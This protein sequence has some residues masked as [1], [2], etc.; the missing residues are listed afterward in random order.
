MST[1][2][3]MIGCRLPHGL[4]LEVGYTVTQKAPDGKRFTSYQKGDNYRMFELKGTN[5]HTAQARAARI[6][7][8]AMASP[9][10]FINKHVPKDIWEQ[11]CKDHPKHWFITSGNIFLVEGS[12]MASAEAMALDLKKTQAPLAPL[13]PQGDDRAPKAVDRADFQ[14]KVKVA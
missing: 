13:N 9:E 5:E 8:P 4:K 10:P 14:A 2:T 7:V 12:E 3:V 1:D 6:V 11:W